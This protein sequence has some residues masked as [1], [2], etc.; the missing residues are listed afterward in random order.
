MT[1]MGCMAEVGGER[2]DILRD[3]ENEKVWREKG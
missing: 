2:R 1:A 3:L